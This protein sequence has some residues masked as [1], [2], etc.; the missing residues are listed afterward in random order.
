MMI[1]LGK[2]YHEIAVGARFQETTAVTDQMVREFAHATGDANPVHLDDVYAAT[3]LFKR[4]IA[5]GMLTAGLISRTLG[6]SFPGAGTI[7]LR[8]HLQ[9]IRPVFIG[10]IITVQLEVVEKIDEKKVIRLTTTCVN[11]NGENVLTGE[12]M[13]VPPS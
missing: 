13:V 5:H 10:D 12:A 6:M 7:Y 4:R 11:Q 1:R 2:K 9:F 3:T 8:Q